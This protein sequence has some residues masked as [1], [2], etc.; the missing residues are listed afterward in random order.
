[1]TVAAE[2]DHLLT[3][4]SPSCGVAAHARHLKLPCDA[5]RSGQGI[6][7]DA[8]AAANRPFTAAGSEVETAGGSDIE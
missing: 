2:P 5:D 6:G 1:M 3:L 7:G 8:D 4:G